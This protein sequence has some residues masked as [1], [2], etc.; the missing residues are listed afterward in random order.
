M[1]VN[2]LRH[3]TVPVVFSISFIK[4]MWLYW[5]HHS[6]TVVCIWR[7]LNAW[8]TTDYA[9]DTWHKLFW[10]PILQVWLLGAQSPVSCPVCELTDSCS[11]WYFNRPRT[12]GGS[13]I[14]C[15]TGLVDLSLQNIDLSTIKPWNHVLGFCSYKTV[16][17]PPTTWKRMVY[18]IIFNTNFVHPSI[19]LWQIKTVK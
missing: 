2:L 18:F 10:V 17:D 1:A 3:I 14:S 12:G 13:P 15:F 6:T 7:S 5:Q 4:H 19:Q 9:C 11:A 16:A 8:F